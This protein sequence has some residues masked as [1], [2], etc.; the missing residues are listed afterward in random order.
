MAP[1]EEV[2]SYFSQLLT[3]INQNP[4]FSITSDDFDKINDMYKRFPLDCMLSLDAL[5]EIKLVYLTCLAIENF[6]YI[7]F[8]K[9]LEKNPFGM[10]QKSYF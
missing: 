5:D 3:K 1:N 8:L 7:D 2:F 6:K 9:D 10:N 4:P